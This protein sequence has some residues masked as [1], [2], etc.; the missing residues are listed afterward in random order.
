MRHS[1]NMF[2]SDKHHVHAITL[3]KKSLTAYDDKRWLYPDGVHSYAYGHF[4]IML[5]NMTDLP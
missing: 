4:A 1:M 3:V 5:E 2:R